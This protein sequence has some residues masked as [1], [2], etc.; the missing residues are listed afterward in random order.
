MQDQQTQFQQANMSSETV[1]VKNKDY[2]GYVRRG[3]NAR[4]EEPVKYEQTEKADVKPK[5][6]AK[7]KK[8][9]GDN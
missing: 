7:P 3:L 1:W 9:E 6:K 2:L 8:T 5:K 4:F